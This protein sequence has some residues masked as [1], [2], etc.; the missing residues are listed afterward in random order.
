MGV[1]LYYRV[2]RSARCRGWE[3]LLSQ[4]CS[5]GPVPLEH[6]TRT[7]RSRAHQVVDTIVE[8]A[9]IMRD[10]STLVVEQ[11]TMLDR[12]DANVTDTS[13]KVGVCV[14][15]VC[16]CVFVCVCACA[17]VCVCV[18]NRTHTPTP[19]HAATCCH[20]TAHL[21]ARTYTPL[22]VESGVRELVRAEQLQKSGRMAQCIVVLIVLVAVFLVITI[23]K[24]L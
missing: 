4:V 22:Q 11:G 16:V 3:W 5:L 7:L 24:H 17:C 21:H 6:P 13:M 10:L 19:K 8:L 12:I 15:A 1:T 9:Q 20:E 23:V 2:C 14:C 18:A